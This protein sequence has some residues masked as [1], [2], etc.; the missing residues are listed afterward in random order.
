VCNCN[1]DE[2]KGVLREGQEESSKSSQQR[3]PIAI[4]SSLVEEDGEAHGNARDRDPGAQPFSC[5][6]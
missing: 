3:R 2:S 1:R 6:G 5:E 4:E